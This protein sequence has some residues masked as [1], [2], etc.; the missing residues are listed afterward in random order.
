MS[1][2]V[3]ACEAASAPETPCVDPVWIDVSGAVP[4]QLTDA[5]LANC[6]EAFAAGFFIV[7]A[8]WGMGFCLSYIADVIKK[9]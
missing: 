9:A 2:W 5:M 4:F 7:T 6:G 1:L 3:Q 8:F